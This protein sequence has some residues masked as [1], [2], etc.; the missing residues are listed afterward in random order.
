[1]SSAEAPSGSTTT[2]LSSSSSWNTSGAVSTQSPEPMQSPRS[3]V[4]SMRFLGESSGM[5]PPGGSATAT[6]HDQG[7]CRDQQDDRHD[8]PRVQSA[9]TALMGLSACGHRDLI[10]GQDVVRLLDPARIGRHALITGPDAELLGCEHVVR[11]V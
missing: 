4:I 6:H 1:M 11:L 10:G 7:K 2:A 3:T 5:R 9:P 8:C